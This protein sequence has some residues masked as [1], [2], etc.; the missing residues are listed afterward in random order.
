MLNSVLWL[1]GFFFLHTDKNIAVLSQLGFFCPHTDKT[2]I[3]QR[4]SNAELPD[5]SPTTTTLEPVLQHYYNLNWP[6]LQHRRQLAKLIMMYRITY[7]LIEIPYITYFIPSRS[8][9][10]G[11]N[12]RY[13]Q[14]SIRVIAYQ[15]PF[16][17][18]AIRLWN[19]L[20]QTLVSSGSIDIFR[21][22]LTNTSPP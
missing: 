21:H 18:S 13:L 15:Y 6:T 8:G 1:V 11:H 9:A 7:H 16:F 19:N 12:I 4:A 22:S 17:P 14:P 10:R 20:P 5:S 3:K 2:S